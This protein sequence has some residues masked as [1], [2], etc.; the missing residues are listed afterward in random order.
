MVEIWVQLWV[1][2]EI[3]RN[4]LVKRLGLVFR[5]YHIDRWIDDIYYGGLS[6][7]ENSYRSS[8][9]PEEPEYIDPLTYDDF[10]SC[11]SKGSID[12]EF[13]KYME[14]E[15]F[16]ESYESHPHIGTFDFTLFIIDLSRIECMERRIFSSL[17]IGTLRN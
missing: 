16:K 17:I 12:S 4:I 14:I 7:P 5:G 3:C 10:K 9:I 8:Y 2:T 1:I 6:A 15:K 11:L 13:L